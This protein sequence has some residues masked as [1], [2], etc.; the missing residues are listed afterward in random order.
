MHHEHKML[1]VFLG[2]LVLII[3][4]LVFYSF[5]PT[6]DIAGQAIA[7]KYKNC[8]DYCTKYCSPAA[9]I[10]YYDGTP[11]EGCK[12]IQCGGNSAYT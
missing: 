4:G 3:G 5:Q 2:I 12:P 1:W 8:D 6:E 7:K 11:T 9:C 10:S